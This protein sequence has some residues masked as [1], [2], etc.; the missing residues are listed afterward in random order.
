MTTAAGP[1]ERA[2]P[3]SWCPPGGAGDLDGR[4]V[5]ILASDDRWADPL[6]AQLESLGEGVELVPLYELIRI[7]ECACSGEALGLTPRNHAEA[8]GG[9]GPVV[10]I[11]LEGMSHRYYLCHRADY[12]LSEGEARLLGFLERTCGRASAGA[13]PGDA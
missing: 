7:Y 11:P 9:A 4:R 5:A 1:G 10:A 3:P 6:A 13:R 2:R 8:L 12:V